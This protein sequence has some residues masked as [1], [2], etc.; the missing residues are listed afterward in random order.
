MS[1]HLR[2]AW[3]AMH[4]NLTATLATLTTMTLTLTILGIVGLVIFNLNSVVSSVEQDVKI[5][6]FLD[7]A[8]ELDYAEVIQ[9]HLKNTETF[10]DIERVV[11]ISRDQALQKLSETYAYLKDAQGLVENPLQDEI[12]VTLKSSQNIDL[13]A[14]SIE[15]MDGVLSV[16]YG[17]EYVGTMIQIINTLRIAGVALVA[18]LLLNSLA[19]ILNT[20][21]VAMYARRDEIN[22]MRL[23]GATRGFIRMPYVLEGVLL[24]LLASALSAAMIYPAYTNGSMQLQTLA[25]FLPINREERVIWLTILGLAGLGV[26]LGLFG[27]LT[28]TNRYLREVE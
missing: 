2:Q 8:P 22:V 11:F 21:R 13:V 12:E 24:G 27:S 3:L 26:V 6:V 16:Q 15:Q 10:P 4:A 7:H 28:A 9:E 17:K 18:L 19:N 5:A 1:Y 20:I 14:S 25:P 23:I